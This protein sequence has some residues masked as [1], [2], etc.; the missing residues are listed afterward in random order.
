MDV[1]A[2]IDAMRLDLKGRRWSEVEAKAMAECRAL[3]VAA[4]EAIAAVD[5][6]AYRGRLTD[7]LTEAMTRATTVGARAV[8]WE[9]D[10][11]NDWDSAFFL[12]RS[13]SPEQTENDEWAAD[14]DERDVI[15]GPSMPEMADLAGASWDQS[16]SDAARNVYL[17]ARTAIAFG[18]AAE[19]V[20]TLGV[21][22]CAGYHD[23]TLVLRIS[24]PR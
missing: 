5:L 15:T 1:N 8:Y 3:D 22:L 13:Y 20:W 4:A 6:A 24:D 14:Y 12:C 21:P 10:T 7:G 17:L 18:Q 2:A 11:D 9:F 23:Q 19:H 16:A